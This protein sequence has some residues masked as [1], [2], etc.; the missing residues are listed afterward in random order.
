MHM[1]HTANFHGSK[2]DNFQLKFVDYFHIFDQNIDCVYA[3]EPPSCFRAKIR[4]IMYTPVN[5]SFT[6]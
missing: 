1:Q 3:L 6:I 5:P 2:N 4:I